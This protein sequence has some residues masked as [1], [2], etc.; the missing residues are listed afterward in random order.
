MQTSGMETSVN[1]PLCGALNARSNNYCV[2]CGKSLVLVND[3]LLAGLKTEAAIAEIDRQVRVVLATV[4]SRDFVVKDATAQAAA[5]VMELIKLFSGVF[6][7]VSAILFVSFAFWD[8][9]TVDDAKEALTR[10]VAEALKGVDESKKAAQEFAQQ[11]Q[12]S[13]ADSAKSAQEYEQ[14]IQGLVHEA[15]KSE[16]KAENE[17]ARKI[18]DISSSEGAF[19]ARLRKAEADLDRAQKRRI[20]EKVLTQAKTDEEIATTVSTAL[21]FSRDAKTTLIL[22]LDT[23][24][25]DENRLER[26]ALS[27]LPVNILPVQS[28]DEAEKQLR[29]HPDVGLVISNF[30]GPKP[31]ALFA[32]DPGYRLLDY[33]KTLPQKIPYIFYSSS[34]SGSRAH[35]MTAHGAFGATN[36]P[37]TL[38]SRVAAAIKN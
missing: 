21:Q 1:C 30:G 11:A 24:G 33:V 29:T 38:F 32:N 5:K 25:R 2:Q 31:K 13:A 17:I 4:T 10:E 7:L 26:E 27:N 12:K 6:L 9:K 19:F 22:W 35:E 18:S 16:E 15:Q 34:A 23:H 37:S 3:A 14:K 28:T 36:D 8:I 20:A